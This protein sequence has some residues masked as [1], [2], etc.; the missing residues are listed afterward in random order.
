MNVPE[1]SIIIPAYNAERWLG[2][3][4]SSVL[5]QSHT[6]L[7]LIIVNDGST[8][9]TLTIAYSFQDERIKVVDQV[10][11]GVSAARNAGLAMAKGTYICFM[12]AD[13]AMLPE[14]IAAKLAF[15]K[16]HGVDWVFSDL[17]LCD[18]RLTPTGEILR[19]TDKDVF[20]TLLLNFSPAVPTS[21]SNV[22][23]HKRCFERGVYFD[24]HLSNVADQDFTLQLSV[25]CS[26][27][28]LPGLFNLYR[29][30]PDSMSKNIALY[31]RD[32]LRFF[33]KSRRMGYLDNRRFR[34]RCMANVYWAIGGSWW[35]LAEKPL[36]AIPYLI[37]AFFY[38]PQVI[39]RPIRKRVW[40]TQ[41]PVLSIGKGSSHDRNRRSHPSA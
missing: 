12:D 20:R 26:Y 13:D 6:D 39:L 4:V 33:E 7:E 25:S 10:N 2:E 28:H 40:V 29:M 31:E 3:A 19:G 27:L 23:A 32:H 38:Q 21:C 24:E 41:L 8:D 16:E 15:L 17:I 35:L 36:H 22:V 11:A 37:K 18:E 30:V 5:N 9:D 1:V 34:R 14:N